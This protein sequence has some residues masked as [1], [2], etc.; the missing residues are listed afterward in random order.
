MAN[1]PQPPEEDK[2]TEEAQQS[3]DKEKA[4]EKNGPEGAGE[5]KEQG[6]PIVNEVEEME[7][8]ENTL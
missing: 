3:D 6:S 4:E 2:E 8:D 5:L 1:I 7:A